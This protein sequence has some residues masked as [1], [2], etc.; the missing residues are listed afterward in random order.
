MDT[1]FHLDPDR[2]LL[3]KGLLFDGKDYRSQADQ[4]FIWP[5]S[6]IVT[7]VCKYE[8]HI[9]E[10]CS[11]GIYSTYNIVYA[12]SYRRTGLGGVLFLLQPGGETVYYED[13]ARS[14]MA[15]LVAVINNYV[16]A[17]ISHSAQRASEFFSIPILQEEVAKIAIDIHM[18][19]LNKKLGL[20]YQLGY[21]TEE[22]ILEFIKS[23]QVGG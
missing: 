17:N 13:G 22:S 1:L 6:G 3:F 21:C 12:L 23:I 7:A 4:G 18:R 5:S 10:N 14:E 20:D 15:Q 8:K 19:Q 2:G 11:C 9:L 16:P